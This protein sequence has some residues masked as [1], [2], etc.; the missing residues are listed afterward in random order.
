MLI[1]W[2]WAIDNFSF[3]APEALLFL[4]LV[5]LF[6]AAY[7]FMQM[8][9]RRYAV[10]YASVSL[11]REAVGKGPGIR[12]HVPAAMYL[13]ALAA[14]AVAMARPKGT[15]DNNFQTGTV[16][17]AIDVS[18]SMAAQD[19]QPT[20]L[21][22]TKKAVKEFI[23]KQP[24]G[25]QVGIVAF[26]GYAALVQPP[27]RDKSVLTRTVDRLALGQG[28]NIGAGLRTALDAVYEA[29]DIAPPPTPTPGA[30]LPQVQPQQPQR[31]AG[32]G[33]DLSSATIILLSDGASTTGPPPLQV[34][35]EVAQAGVKVY[36]IGVGTVQG[37]VVTAAGRRV[38]VQLDEDTLSGIAEATGGKYVNAQTEK[39]LSRVYG[40]LASSRESERQDRDLTYYV[41]GIGLLFA[42]IAGGLSLAWFNRLP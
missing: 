41:T 28:T 37:G 11:L 40:D 5:P 15:V 7:V 42:V 6:A 29:L 8:R 19:V 9:R 30:G 22:A 24:K 3:Q 14:M 25:V 13:L 10:R 35:D 2:P 1:T 4:L 27:T 12:R 17:L 39:D 23:S 36:T 18:L 34:A 26:A 38:F 20:R 16:I 21:D 33:A 32:P 31:Q